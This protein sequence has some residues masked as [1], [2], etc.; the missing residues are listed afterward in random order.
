MSLTCVLSLDNDDYNKL[1]IMI[2]TILKDE[3]LV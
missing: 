1:M 2:L 3:N